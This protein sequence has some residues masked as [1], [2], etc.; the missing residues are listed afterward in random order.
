MQVIRCSLIVLR[1]HDEEHT[2]SPHAQLLHLA[3]G[4]SPKPCQTDL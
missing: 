1:T 2:N 3:W 4:S